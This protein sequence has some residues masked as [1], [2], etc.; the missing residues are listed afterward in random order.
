MAKTPEQNN[1][2]APNQQVDTRIAAVRDL[3]FGENIQRYDSEFADVYEKI[4]TL[5]NQSNHSLA[6]AVTNL[7]NKLS[8]LESLVDH[9]FQDLNDDL[10][11]KLA[12]LDDEKAD[13]RK[14]GKAL[15]KIAQMLQE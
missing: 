9:K 15:E 14:L 8:D 10:D 12:D 11:K 6:E 3:I 1:E 2:A 7:E 13:R 4:E 5:K